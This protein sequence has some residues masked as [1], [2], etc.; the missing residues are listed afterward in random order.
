[1]PKYA[2]TAASSSGES[3]RGILDATTKADLAKKLSKMGL[4]LVSC[5]AEETDPTPAAAAATSSPAPSAQRFKACVKAADAMTQSTVNVR[6]IYG[7][8]ERQESQRPECLS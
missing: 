3:S 2:Y 6:T 1:M 8:H 5:R 7:T 4:F